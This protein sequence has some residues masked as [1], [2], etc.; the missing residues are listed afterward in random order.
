MV[1][2]LPVTLAFILLPE[3]I[4]GYSYL[5]AFELLP[6]DHDWY[7]VVKYYDTKKQCRFHVQAYMQPFREYQ[8]SA[9]NKYIVNSNLKTALTTALN[10]LHD[11]VNAFQIPSEEY[12]NKSYEADMLLSANSVFRFGK[13]KKVRPIFDPDSLEAFSRQRLIDF[14]AND[15]RYIVFLKRRHD[16]MMVLQ[17]WISITDRL[18]EEDFRVL[19]PR[20][21]DLKYA[22]EQ[23]IYYVSEMMEKT[24]EYPDR[25]LPIGKYLMMRLIKD[26]WVRKIESMGNGASISATPPSLYLTFVAMLYTLLVVLLF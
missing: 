11:A 7:K 9:K 23:I 6:S 25:N 3:I 1:W 12:G 18:P 20:N 4:A 10:L 21:L 17:E 8:V 2:L 15:P 13:A 24:F 16:Y 5:N 22:E 26:E 14:F 19:M